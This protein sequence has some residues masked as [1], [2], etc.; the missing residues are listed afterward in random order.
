MK[1]GYLIFHHNL[2][3]SSIPTKHYDFIIENIYSKLLDICEDNTKLAFEFNGYTLQTINSISK[4]YIERLKYLIKQ[5]KCQIIGSSYTQ[6]AFPLI[7]AKVNHANLKIGLEIYNEILGVVP[8]TCLL[9]E[10]I[11]S[12]SV[13]SLIKKAGYKNIIFDFP[14]A[15]IDIPP[16]TSCEKREPV[17]HNDLGIIWGDSVLT[18]KFQKAVWQD[19]DFDDYFNY[20]KKQGQSNIPLYCGDAEVFEYIPGS[21]NFSKKGQDF[22]NLKALIEKIKQLEVE[23]ILP[24]QLTIKE[25]IEDFEIATAKFPIKT[26]KQ[27]KYNITRWAV[28]GRDSMKMNTQ[29]YSLYGKI[30]NKKNNE[31]MKTLC[32]LWASDF[33]TNTT[34]EK[35]LTFRNKMGAALEK[36]QNAKKKSVKNI[37]GDSYKITEKGRYFT[38]ETGNILLT[39]IKNKGLAIKKLHFKKKHSCSCIGTIEQGY[40]ENIE[41]GA[42]FFSMH[43]IVVSKEGRQITDLSSKVTDL[44]VFVDERGVVVT[45]SSPMNLQNFSIIKEYVL[46]DKLEVNIKFY[47]LDLYPTSIRTGIITFLPEFLNNK[48]F[49]YSTYNGGFELEEFNVENQTIKHNSP[50]NALVSATSCL[51]DSEGLINFQCN[52]QSLTIKTSKDKC[53]T[54]PLLFH[55]VIDNAH[56][57]R[58]FNSMCEQDDI[59]H[60]FF[61]GYQEFTME[62]IP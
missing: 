52:K 15:F 13:A 7:P 38:I 60:Q 27:P 32:F 19:I 5:N 33:R 34:D 55:K 6:A 37:S 30:K 62:I 42:D 59:S 14:N 24:N 58:V 18:Q 17:K 41:F 46:S 54:V 20:L 49:C 16:L 2:M 61:K 57:C 29:C 23:I 21:L 39:L 36:V 26:K 56:F 1:K 48:S 35:Y 25:D 10:Q 3:F 44:K 50:V 28:T 43:T 53:Y 47:F 12:K 45:H 40:F 22:E 8:D 11:Y 51:G 9:N 4:K 31:L